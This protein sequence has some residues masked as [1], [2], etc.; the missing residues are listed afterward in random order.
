LIEDIQTSTSIRS[1]P[2]STDISNIMSPALSCRR[3]TV[4]T[5]VSTAQE[6]EHCIIKSKKR[7]S[8]VSFDKK[9]LLQPYLHVNDLLD[10][11]IDN[12]WYS[13][14]ELSET[15]SECRHT[16]NSMIAGY[17]HEEEDTVY[18]SRGLERRTPAC[19]KLRQ[20]TKFDAWDVV[21]D[22]QDR[23]RRAGV[24]DTESLAQGYSAC[25]SHSAKIAHLMAVSDERAVNPSTS[26]LSQ[27]TH[28]GGMVA[29]PSRPVALP[30]R[31]R[32]SL[33]RS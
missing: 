5:T 23:Q 11:E 24:S 30:S 1:P 15:K 14:T 21:L 20:Q 25:T 17:C 31:P 19:Q 8:C 4:L 27:I 9:V 33:S 7:R 22:E 18:C 3:S 12:A 6:E 16:I 10:D 29:F 28:R 26:V 32:N 2:P 13:R